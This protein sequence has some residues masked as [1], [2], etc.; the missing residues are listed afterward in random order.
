[1]DLVEKKFKNLT[2]GL[3]PKTSDENS[4]NSMIQAHLKKRVLIKNGKNEH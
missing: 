2:L 1:M 4:G 3:N